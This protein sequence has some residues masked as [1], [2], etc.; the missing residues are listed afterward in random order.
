MILSAA[1]DGGAEATDGED[2]DD[3]EDGD[4]FE[5]WVTP[6]AAGGGG[7]G[8]AEGPAVGTPLGRVVVYAQVKRAANE[9]EGQ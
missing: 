8:W 2:E 5:A 6:D 9:G 1:S 4:L 7:G 3:D